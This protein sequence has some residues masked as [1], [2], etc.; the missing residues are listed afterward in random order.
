MEK[1]YKPDSL[2]DLK[3]R[4]VFDIVDKVSLDE[5]KNEL[6]CLL[7]LFCFFLYA[8]GENM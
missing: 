1:K 8:V 4:G 3:E 7:I 2:T 5:E 6:I